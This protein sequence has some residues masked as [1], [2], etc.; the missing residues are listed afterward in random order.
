MR[1]RTYGRCAH[2]RRQIWKSTNGGWYH[3]ANGSASCK[4]GQSDRKAYPA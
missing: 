2:C 4:P 3:Y 1:E